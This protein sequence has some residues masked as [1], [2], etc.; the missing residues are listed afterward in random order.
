MVLTHLIYVCMLKRSQFE[1]IS[2]KITRI[3]MRI[4]PNSEIL[5]S[6]YSFHILSILSDLIIAETEVVATA[7][8]STHV[9]PVHVPPPP[10]SAPPDIS[11]A[12]RGM[13][14]CQQML[15]ELAQLGWVSMIIY[16]SQLMSRSAMSQP[17]RQLRLD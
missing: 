15:E 4:L 14:S 1:G 9:P 11:N 17:I 8:R 2:N 3:G 6:I 13:V 16:H 10:P 7:P 5:S 12:S